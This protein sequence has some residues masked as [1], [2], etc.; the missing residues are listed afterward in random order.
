VKIKVLVQH[1]RHQPQNSL[2]KLRDQEQEQH[3]NQHAR[4]PIR[5]LL[6]RQQLHRHLLVSG[7]LFLPL[8]RLIKRPNELQRE[9]R[10]QDA[11][12]HLDDHR[13][14][15]QERLV[16][17]LVELRRMHVV[18]CDLLYVDMAVLALGRR[19]EQQVRVVGPRALDLGLIVPVHVDV[20][21]ADAQRHVVG[22]ADDRRDH[23]G[24][25][26]GEQR[27]VHDGGL[28]GWM[29]HGDVAPEGEDYREEDGD[30]VRGLAEHGVGVDVVRVAVGESFEPRVYAKGIVES[31]WHVDEHHEKVRDGETGE[32]VVD[33]RAEIFAGKDDK[34]E[35]VGDA[36]ES[37]NAQ[38]ELE[39]DRVEAGGVGEN[40]VISFF[41]VVYG[42]ME[43]EGR[44]DKTVNDVE[45]VRPRLAKV[46]NDRT[47]MNHG[48]SRFKMNE[49]SL[50]ELGQR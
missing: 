47:S 29:A 24:R 1:G 22:Q 31:V 44:K 20:L 13:I 7:Q 26:N 43:F 35:D 33:V 36:A 10:Q 11:R 8:L 16:V 48:W 2:R 18:L 17:V 23:V 4:R 9:K 34:V 14:H 45:M 27:V 39:V 25:D 49:P 42:M 15:P 21:A 40:C 37:T 28:A 50:P 46:K 19:N 32:D 3:G 6:L 38:A 12:Q 41:C 30:G 5:L